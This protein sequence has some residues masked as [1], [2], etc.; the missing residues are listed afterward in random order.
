MAI[1]KVQEHQVVVKLNGTNQLLVYTDDVNLLGDNMDTT[2]KSIETMIDASEEVRLGVNAEKTEYKRRLKPDNAF[3]HSVQNLLSLRLLSK[4]V[5][6]R[7]Y[8]TRMLPVV[9]IGV[10]LGL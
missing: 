4:H 3:Y 8:R 7:I 6:I 9:C 2:K 5:K 1:R 10:K